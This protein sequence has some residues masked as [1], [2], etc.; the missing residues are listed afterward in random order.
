MTDVFRIVVGVD[1]SPA[2]R[3]ALRYAVQTAARTNGTVTAISAW[4]WDGAAIAPL[5]D[6]TP[7]DAKQRA[8]RVM[9]AEL[10]SIRSEFG[11]SVPVTGEVIQGG[12]A[13]DVLVRASKDADLLVIGSHGHSRMY[14]AVLGSVS[15]RCVRHATCPVVV[16][17]AGAYERD[18]A[19]AS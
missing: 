12:P 14:H 11:S 16:I 17:P 19:T 13:A 15:D 2:G 6:A 10:D 5:V 1:G 18:L 9:A 7:G 4:H 8:D 3:A